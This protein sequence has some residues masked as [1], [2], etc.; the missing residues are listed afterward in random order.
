M[1]I[2]ISD[3]AQGGTL[4]Q[5]SNN[6]KLHPNTFY[7]RHFSPTEIN[8]EIDNKELLVIVNYFKV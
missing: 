2:D 1:E 7:S 4:S 8:Y 3:F 6:K 5:V